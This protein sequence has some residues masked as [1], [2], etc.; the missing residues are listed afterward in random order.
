MKARC[1]KLKKPLVATGVDTASSV[2]EYDSLSNCDDNVNSN[3]SV[4]AMGIMGMCPIMIIC[5][6]VFAACLKPSLL[7]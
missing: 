4:H 1:I 2:P 6:P 7:K 3:N 5:L